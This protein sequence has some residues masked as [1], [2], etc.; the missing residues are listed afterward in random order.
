LTS[1]IVVKAA[2]CGL[3]VV[4]SRSAPTDRAVSLARQAGLTLI[5]FA[6]GTRMNVYS[7]FERIEGA[8]GRIENGGTV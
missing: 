7:G 8:S 5:G 6:R 1:E 2:R 4:V 3:P